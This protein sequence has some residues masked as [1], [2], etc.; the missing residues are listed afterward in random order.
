MERR[1]ALKNIGFGSATLFSSS[2]LFGTMQGCTT[3]LSVDW[4]PVFFRP[5]EAGQMEKI[6]E[7]IAPKITTLGIDIC[8]N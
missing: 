1:K 6:C 8:L 2:M 5:E 4:I 3:R 7:G